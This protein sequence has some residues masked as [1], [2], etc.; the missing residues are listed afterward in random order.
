MTELTLVQSELIKQLRSLGIYRKW[1]I[2]NTL[3]QGDEG[4]TEEHDW[5]VRLCIRDKGLVVNFDITFDRGQDLYN[6]KAWLI[7]NHVDVDEAYSAEGL[8]WNQFPDIIGY[9]MKDAGKM[10]ALGTIAKALKIDGK[11]A[12]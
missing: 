6:V 12:R 10:Q 1:N 2:K 5:D 7:R 3:V 8:F 9:A 11:D 4:K